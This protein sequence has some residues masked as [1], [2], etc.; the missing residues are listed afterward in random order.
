MDALALLERRGGLI[1]GVVFSGGEPT[2]HRALP[3]AMQIVREM[4]FDVALHTAGAYPAR[5]KRLLPLVDWVGMDIKAPPDRYDTITR[6]P[7]SGRRAWES[8]RLLL[9]SGV[10]HEF[11]TTVH[12]S[13]TSRDDVRAIATALADLGARR[14]VLQHCVTHTTLDPILTSERGKFALTTDDIVALREH[15]PELSLRGIEPVRA[16]I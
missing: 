6:T 16:A 8:A 3:D 9:E 1:D 7:S 4:G 13:L 5:L 11:R 10:D 14:Y 12:P 2:V 15:I